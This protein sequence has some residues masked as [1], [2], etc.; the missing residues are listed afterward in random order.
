MFIAMSVSGAIPRLSSIALSC[1]CPRSPRALFVGTSEAVVLK[2]HLARAPLPLRDSIHLTYYPSAYCSKHG[3]SSHLCSHLCCLYDA[4]AA[5]QARPKT[6]R[7]GSHRHLPLRLGSVRSPP[8]R[9]AV[10][11]C[12]RVQTGT[13][14]PFTQPAFIHDLY[15]RLLSPRDD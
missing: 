3:L 11:G 12:E 14:L 8:N 13:F 15:S 6:S 5:K 2:G 7:C 9:L 4:S 10:Y 1:L